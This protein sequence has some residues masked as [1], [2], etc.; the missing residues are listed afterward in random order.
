MAT[1]VMGCEEAAVDVPCGDADVS[2]NDSACSDQLRLNNINLTCFGAFCTSD[3][4]PRSH[5]GF[6]KRK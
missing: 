4:V 5:S 6:S 1:A 2:T 3:M